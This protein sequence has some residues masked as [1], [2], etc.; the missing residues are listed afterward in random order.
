MRSRDLVVYLR[1]R[2]E[3]LIRRLRNDSTRPLL[4]VS[5]PLKR[6]REIYQE[7]EPLYQ[8][9]AHVIVETGRDPLSVLVNKVLMQTELA[10]ATYRAS[11]AP[12]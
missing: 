6:L 4:Q 2:P 5:D 1:A 7:R 12:S 11:P 8:E 10:T 3:Y 9:V